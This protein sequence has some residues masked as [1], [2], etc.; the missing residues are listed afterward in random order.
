MKRSASALA[1]I[2]K[3]ILFFIL[4]NGFIKAA[5]QNGSQGKLPFKTTEKER[6]SLPASVSP[7]PLRKSELSL[8]AAPIEEQ[9][10]SFFDQ[11]LRLEKNKDWKGLIGLSK[12]WSREFPQEAAPHFFLG[13]AY[14]SL[15]RYRKATGEYKKALR[16]KEDFPKAWCN[17]GSCYVYLKRYSKAIEAFKRA[18]EEYPS[19]ARAWSNLGG[20]YIE[21]GDYRS[22]INALEKAISL[23]PDLPE[24]WCNLGSAYGEIKEYKKAIDSL[25]RAT[26]IKAD[27]LEAWYNLSR[28]YGL[29]HNLEK[30]TEAEGK[31]QEII[32]KRLRLRATFPK[33]KLNHPGE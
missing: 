1:I 11:A 22:A 14:E 16:L 21:L 5:S 3:L 7:S 24:A 25:Q 32:A 18:I 6:L 12:N 13:L 9:E 30:K 33:E 2:V 27:Y 31:I 19:F 17:L 20:C 8:I 26:K 4:P 29:L 23:R 15:G 28:L 10:R